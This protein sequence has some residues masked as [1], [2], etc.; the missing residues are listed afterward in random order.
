MLQSGKYT[1]QV[2]YQMKYGDNRIVRFPAFVQ[3]KYSG[4]GVV[5]IKDREERRVR[6]FART[7]KEI[8]V[9]GMLENEVWI[10]LYH[11]SRDIAIIEVLC[12]TISEEALVNKMFNPINDV[13]DV[14]AI[15]HDIL[16]FEDYFFQQ[17]KEI[18]LERF[19][20]LLIAY[21]QMYCEHIFLPDFIVAHKEQDYLKYYDEIV[22]QGGEGIIIKAFR[23]EYAT[24]SRNYNQLKLKFVTTF[25]LLCV[26]VLYKPDGDFKGIVCKSKEG[27]TYNVYVGF[28][29]KNK[30]LFAT[31]SDLI[32]GKVV[33]IQ[34]KKD[35]MYKLLVF[36]RIREDKDETQLD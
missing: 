26:G 4:I 11:S 24:N 1:P 8:K 30:E 2:V 15:V 28:S 35:A 14:Y 20:R 7:G 6:F 16:T 10:L 21:K 9:L 32:V 22:G 19:R 5:C 12:D 36:K 17:D 18:Y 27:K 34:G 29:Q 25:D 3:K 13:T 23:G 33:E 31:H